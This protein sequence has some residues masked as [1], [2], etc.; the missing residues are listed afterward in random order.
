MTAEVLFSLL[1]PVTFFV[2]LAIESLVN[3][4][5]P[6]PEIPWCSA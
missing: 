4:G 3:T 6:W 5:R 2:L 1:V